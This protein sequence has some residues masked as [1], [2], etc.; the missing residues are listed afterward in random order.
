MHARPTPQAPY[1]SPPPPP[2]A[3]LQVYCLPDNYE[4]VDRSMDDIRAVLNPTFTREQV[5]GWGFG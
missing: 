2:A 3:F 4:V 5:W 1:A